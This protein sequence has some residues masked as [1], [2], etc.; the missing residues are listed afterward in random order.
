MGLQGEFLT[1]TRAA[2]P[3]IVKSE[4]SLGLGLLMLVMSKVNSGKTFYCL[5]GHE[6]GVLEDLVMSL[7]FSLVPAGR[8]KDFSLVLAEW[9]RHRLNCT[10]ARAGADVLLT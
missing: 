6:L 3:F 10:A 7:V 4:P 2:E 1:V 9:K 5:T 8:R